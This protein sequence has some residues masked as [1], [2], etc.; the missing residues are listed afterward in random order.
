MLSADVLERLNDTLR[1][2]VEVDEI[3]VCPHDDS[4]DCPCR[5][6]R[7]GMLISAAERRQLDLTESFMV[8]DRWRDIEAGQRAGCGTVLID[9]GYDERAVDTADCVV[10]DLS[11]AAA[12]ILEKRASNKSDD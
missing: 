5:K 6:P 12:W 1:E 4:D 10:S 9:R 7:P 11:E 2:A 8:G 3:V